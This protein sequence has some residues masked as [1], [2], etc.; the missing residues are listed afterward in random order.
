MDELI[1]L[2]QNLTDEIIKISLSDLETI[3]KYKKIQEVK[4]EFRKKINL[5]VK[6]IIK[7]E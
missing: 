5:L 7:Y 1:R 2:N 6:N 3:E 4:E